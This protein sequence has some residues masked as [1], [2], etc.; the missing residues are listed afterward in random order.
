MYGLYATK[1]QSPLQLAQQIDLRSFLSSQQGVAEQL[2]AECT[3]Y[4]LVAMSNHIGTLNQGHYTAHVKVR[5][6]PFTD[7]M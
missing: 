6:S 5:L 3:T 4:E 7:A 1:N 2:A